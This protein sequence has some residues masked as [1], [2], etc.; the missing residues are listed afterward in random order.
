MIY[1]ICITGHLDY[2]WGKWFDGMSITHKGNGTTELKGL[3]VDQAALYGILKKLR[4][5][6]ATLRSLNCVRTSKRNER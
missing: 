3:V 2:R 1:C 6:G 4:D 5:L